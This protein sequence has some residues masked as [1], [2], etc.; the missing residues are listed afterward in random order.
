M[1]N[2][3]GRGGFDQIYHEHLSYFSLTALKCLIETS[4]LALLDAELIPIHGESLRVYAGKA[5]RK[6]SGRAVNILQK[7]KELGIDKIETYHRFA[8]EVEKNKKELKRVID[9]IKH[10]GKSI[11]GYGAPAKGNTLLNYCG[12]DKAGVDYII[13]T[14]PFKQGLFAPGSRIPIFAPDYFK[15]SPPDYMLLLAWNYKDAI[16]DKEKWFG[17]QGG[18]WIIPV[19]RVEI[20]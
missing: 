14:T 9:D 3:I 12:I 11:A 10:A 1:E 20:Q 18:K 17:E 13:D 8:E 2:L 15:K 19:P 4:G 16:L 5:G 7:E 6:I